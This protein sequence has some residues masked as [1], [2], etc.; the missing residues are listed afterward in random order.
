MI[1]T[2]CGNN[3]FK[4]QI[5]A[6]AADLTLQGHII[7]APNVFYYD[8][9]EEVPQEVIIQL[10]NLHREKINMSDA[11]FVVNV[12][13]QIDAN[14]YAEIDWAQRMK[15]EVYFL[16]GAEQPGGT[17]GDGDDPQGGTTPG[18]NEGSGGEGSGDDVTPPSGSTD[19]PPD[20]ELENPTG[21][22]GE[23]D[24]DIP[25]DNPND[26]PIIYD[27][28]DD[29]NTEEDGNEGYGEEGTEINPEDEDTIELS[30]EDGNSSSDGDE[31][32][33]DNNEEPTTENENT[34][35]TSDN[36]ED[37]PVINT[38]YNNDEPS[39]TESQD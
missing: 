36:G 11:I 9:T 1:I 23:D 28:N 30:N 18:D 34:S 35:N 4:E 27:D 19:T 12:D 10:G 37:I 14:T 20:D 16:N 7:L 33:S 15:K 8:S 24:T 29:G 13:E 26:G 38:D 5:E 25:D 6:V 21:D 22:Y 32:T 39:P 2:I 17:S 31:T 3:Q